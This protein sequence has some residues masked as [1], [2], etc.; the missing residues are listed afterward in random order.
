[1]NAVSLLASILDCA[2]ADYSLIDANPL[3]GILR[4]RNFPADIRPDN[5]R[6][7]YLEP[8]DFRKAVAAIRDERVRNAVVFAGL[9]GLRWSEQVALRVEDC[10]LRRN[11]LR[12]SRSLY[13][14]TPQ[15]P[16]TRRAIGEVDMT[17]MVRR[18]VGAV[19]WTEGYIFSHDGRTPIGDGSWIKKQWRKA[20]GK[21]GIRR[22]IGWHDLRHQFV[23]LLIAAGKHPKYISNQAR[24]FSAGFTLDRYG[25]L[26]ES[27]PTTQ[28]E[29]VDEL[30]WPQGG[31]KLVTQEVAK[32]PKRQYEVDS[33]QSRKSNISAVFGRS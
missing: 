22:P 31:N 4:R 33:E 5:D 25:D 7:R 11:K 24:H 29:W 15:T 14:R 3:R 17:P 32:G 13:R 30:V 26:F 2:A 16:K 8:E 21:A 9:T 27:I 18:I 6:P 19:P 20:Q 23:T 1:M 10:D 28:V 12:V